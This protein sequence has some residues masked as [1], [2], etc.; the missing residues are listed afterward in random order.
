MYNILY[1]ESW[2]NYFNISQVKQW[3]WINSMRTPIKN[4]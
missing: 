3:M 1:L 4:Q 2:V